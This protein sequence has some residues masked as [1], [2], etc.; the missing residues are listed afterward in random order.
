MNKDKLNIII[1]LLLVTIGLFIN[2]NNPELKILGFL[3]CG[4]GGYI[5]GR[6]FAKL[7]H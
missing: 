6:S 2:V 4:I 7:I 1:G 5:I 3:L